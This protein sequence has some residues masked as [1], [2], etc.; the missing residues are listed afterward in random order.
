M[1]LCARIRDLQLSYMLVSEGPVQV[2][3]TPAH[4]SAEHDDLEF[5]VWQSLAPPERLSRVVY[6]GMGES[7]DL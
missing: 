1:L 2:I 7:P 5:S 3:L 4:W 6:E